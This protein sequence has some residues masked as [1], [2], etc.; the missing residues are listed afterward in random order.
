MFGADLQKLS[1][2]GYASW[3]MAYSGNRINLT[4]VG[5]QGG[6]TVEILAAKFLAAALASS[7]QNIIF[8]G[9]VN[10]AASSQTAAATVS[11]ITSLI[12]KP[13]LAS[14]K[15]LFLMSVLPFSSSHA[16][17]AT[18]NPKI[19]VIN[20]ALKRYCQSNNGVVLV[21]GYSALVNPT[22]ATPGDVIAGVMDSSFLHPSAKGAALVG[23][24]L[25]TAVVGQPI[26]SIDLLVQASID[27]FGS[28]A[29]S[30]NLLDIG[31][32]A[33]AGGTIGTLTGTLPTGWTGASSGTITS[34]VASVVARAD[35]VGSDAQIVI[36]PGAAYC[37]VF[38]NSQTGQLLGRIVAGAWY[39]LGVEVTATGIAASNCNNITT[40]LA[41]NLDGVAYTLGVVSGFTSD[42]AQASDL[43]ALQLLS[44][45]FW[46]PAGVAISAPMMYLACRFSAAS[47][48]AMTVKYGRATLR[49][50]G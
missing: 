28:N 42:T 2:H 34:A 37:Q 13:I 48:S 25:S 41:L 4:Y 26:P 39:Q 40:Y 15:R 20:D 33:G 19:P 14:G 1:Q 22:A 29:Q 36:T 8:M 35:G 31:L 27:Q 49:K 16:S 9:G 11:A 10:N 7:A 45:P 6:A 3:A 23:A 32:M 18:A 50:I 21:D 47:A 43:T 30:N 46:I 17:F 5:V 24:K 38:L 12:C 44:L